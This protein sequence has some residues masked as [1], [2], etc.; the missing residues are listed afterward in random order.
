MPTPSSSRDSSAPQHRFDHPT[1]SAL[2]SAVTA[3]PVSDAPTRPARLSVASARQQI[4]AENH[5]AAHLSLPLLDAATHWLRQQ[6][7]P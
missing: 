1:D 2:W 4:R 7:R 6:A 3:W 5:H